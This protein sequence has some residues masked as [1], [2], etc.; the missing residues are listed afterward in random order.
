MKKTS[1]T[2]S[3]TQPSPWKTFGLLFIKTTLLS[4]VFVFIFLLITLLAVLAGV[5]LRLSAFEKAA[6]ISRSELLTAVQTGL[7]QEPNQTENRVNILI[8]GLDT[9]A[10]RGSVEPLTDTMVIVSLHIDTGEV[11]LL[12][13]PRDLWSDEYKTKINALYSYGDERYPEKPEQFPREVL[14]KQLG[15]PL[16]YTVLISIDTLSKLIDA[17]GGVT[18]DVP[19]AFTDTEFP[20]SDV[21]VT[22]EQDPA[23]LYKT[24]SFDKGSQEMSGEK[25]LE[26]IRSRHSEGQEGT[27][28][29]RSMRQQLV[30][31]AIAAKLLTRETLTSPEKAAELY[32][33]Y[34]TN[35]A[36]QLPLPTLVSIAKKLYP[37][38]ES[39]TL[40]SESLTIYPED[41]NGLLVHPPE[42][43]YQNQ[44]VY[45]MRDSTTFKAAVLKMLLESE[46]KQ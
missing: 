10:N 46:N 9:L 27:D 3:A 37:V 22:V 41:P 30:I 1:E 21:D 14:E 36:E 24:V 13:L 11:H 29:S 31:K 8:L 25:A 43:Q 26:Y 18:V 28:I 15:L 23:K 6:N 20:R 44:W 12:S 16:H 39:I 42:R 19:T 17:L 45:I 34:Q 35:F 2:P 40:Y 4:F 7:Q 5:H 33:L 32:T 38:R